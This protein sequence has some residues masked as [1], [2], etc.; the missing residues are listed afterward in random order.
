MSY[1]YVDK[2]VTNFHTTYISSSWT[3][4]ETRKAFAYPD[5]FFQDGHTATNILQNILIPLRDELNEIEDP[6]CLPTWRVEVIPAHQSSNDISFIR[7]NLLFEHA[8]DSN[9]LW[10]MYILMYENG[11]VKVGVHTRWGKLHNA[12]NSIVNMDLFSTDIQVREASWR[13]LRRHIKEIYEEN[14]KEVA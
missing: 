1:L 2:M 3:S 10:C 4:A 11:Q 14:K 5:P 8:P 9:L 13:L 6:M 7:L 12:L